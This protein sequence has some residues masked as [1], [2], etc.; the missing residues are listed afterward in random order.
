[1]QAVVHR[2]RNMAS[3]KLVANPAGSRNNGT[4]MIQWEDT[5]EAD[6]EW[7]FDP[8]LGTPGSDDRYDHR[9]RLR[10]M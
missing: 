5:G 4:T 1:M 6:Q 7:L 2:I 10:P 3:R 9:R 8:P